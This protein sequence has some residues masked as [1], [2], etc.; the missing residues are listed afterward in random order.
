MSAELIITSVSETKPKLV[1]GEKISILAN[2]DQTGCY[3][4]YLHDA[5]ENAGP[6]P[7]C[8]EW[9]EAFY[10]IDGA[11]EFNCGGL[12][13]MVTAGG[14]VHVPSGTVHSFRYASATAQILGITSRGGA[15]KM[16]AAVDSECGPAPQI[17]KLIGV[18]STNGVQVVL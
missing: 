18:L 2:S 15:A 5:P 8:H 6:P 13:R 1:C 17:D 4:V 11:V 7:H 16:F 3:E 10:V 12:I 9:D 14:F